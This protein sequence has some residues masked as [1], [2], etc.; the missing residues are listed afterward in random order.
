MF[1]IY[2]K[3]PILLQRIY[4]CTIKKCGNLITYDIPSQR[5][6]FYALY[7]TFLTT[8]DRFQVELYERVSDSFEIFELN[9][10]VFSSYWPQK[11]L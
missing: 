1:I 7:F 6:C 5:Y 4:I 9:L 10:C 11:Q 3:I 8:L 2:K